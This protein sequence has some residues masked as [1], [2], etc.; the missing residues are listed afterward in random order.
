MISKLSLQLKVVIL[1]LISLGIA[2]FVIGGKKAINPDEA[3]LSFSEFDQVITTP[4]ET[5]SSVQ[6]ADYLM[7]QEHHY[8]LIDLQGKNSGY[9]IPTSESHSIK[10]FLELKI[11]VNETVFIYSSFETE[12]LQLYYLLL[13]RG[14]FKVKILA[15]G[16][17]AWTAQILQPLK[18][19]IPAEELE[20]RKRLTNFF[21]GSIRNESNRSKSVSFKPVVLEKKKKKH[22]GC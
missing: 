10:S 2:S 5:I 15:G 4:V 20:H 12:A 9:Q 17:D 7:K 14:Y 22:Q 3:S 18:D 8:N 19:D 1:I 13:I 6:L 16:I 11:P 21:G